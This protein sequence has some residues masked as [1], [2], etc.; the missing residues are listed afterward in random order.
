MAYVQ[1]GHDAGVVVDLI[2][3]PVLPD[4]DAPAV[5]ACELAATR[6]SRLVSQ[7]ADGIPH[8]LV[9]LLGSRANDR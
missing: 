9:L 1:Y 6:R 4:T 7:G 8:T 3:H 2:N 5:S